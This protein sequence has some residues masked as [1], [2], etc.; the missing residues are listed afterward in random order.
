MYAMSSQPLRQAALF[1]DSLARGVHPLTQKQLSQDTVLSEPEII[2][3]LSA[4]SGMLTGLC[5]LPKKNRQQRMP[6]SRELLPPYEYEKDLPITQLTAQLNRH[7]DQ[8][9]MKKLPYTRIVAWLEKQGLLESVRDEHTGQNMR[10]ATPAGCDEGLYMENRI[11][12]RGPYQVC[13]YSRRAQEYVVAHLE[14]IL[15]DDRI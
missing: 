10:L 15:E 9:Q 6:Y 12:S 13:M 1:L 8:E 4:I 7:V 5:A 2:R 3:Q 11:S 14:E